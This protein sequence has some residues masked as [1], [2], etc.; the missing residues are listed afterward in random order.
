MK[1]EERKMQPRAGSRL[2]TERRH[3]VLLKAQSCF[4]PQTSEDNNSIGTVDELNNEPV[5][6]IVFEIGMN[7]PQ[8]IY[9]KIVLNSFYVDFHRV[10]SESISGAS[11]AKNI[12]GP[13]LLEDV[14]NLPSG[15]IIVVQFNRHNQSIEKEGRKFASFLVI[16]ARTPDLTLLNTNDWRVF[17][18]EKIKLVEFVR[19]I[20]KID[21]TRA[22]VYILSHTKCKDCRPLNE[23]SPNTI[24]MMKEKFSNGETSEEKSLVSV[25]CKGDMYS[26][27]LENEKS[28]Y[29]Y[30][31][32][33]GPTPSLLWGKLPWMRQAMW[34]YAPIELTRLQIMEALLD[35]LLDSKWFC[36]DDREK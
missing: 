34:K 12:H 17:D 2:I 8:W 6:K 14:W 16:I 33:L 29:V 25:A 10:S 7:F 19:T 13:T 15:E 28:G 9:L 23:E 18:E 35:R 36:Q 32:G 30:G 26:Q 3:Q 31:L 22:K 20:D 11:K 5:L 27:V 1:I 21:P 4:Q 24:N